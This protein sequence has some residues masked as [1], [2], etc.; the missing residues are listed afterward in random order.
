MK[1]TNLESLM[2]EWSK[3]SEINLSALEYESAKNGKL[4]SKYLNYMTYHNMISKSM[5]AEYV[6]LKRLKTEYYSGLHNTNK[7]FLDKYGLEPVR[8]LILKQEIPMYLDSDKDLIKL[9]LRKAAHDEIVEY[10]KVVIKEISNRQWN[11]RNS[12]EF[13]KFTNGG[14]VKM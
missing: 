5:S 11:I 10:C 13:M 9:S 8:N 4:H 12:I 6:E 7:E 3:D 14:D 1:G 2:E